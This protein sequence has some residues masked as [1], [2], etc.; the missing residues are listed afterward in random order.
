MEGS[1]LKAAYKELV[2]KIS[3]S[4]GLKILDTTRYYLVNECQGDGF[5]SM[6]MNGCQKTHNGWY[7]GLVVSVSSIVGLLI[8]SS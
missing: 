6:G 5:S 7:L 1:S 2:K 8:L 4:F 3:T